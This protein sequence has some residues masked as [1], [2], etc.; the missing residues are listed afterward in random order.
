MVF[1]A[2]FVAMLAQLDQ[3]K[4][5]RKTGHSFAYLLTV[6]AVFLASLLFSFLY[7]IVQTF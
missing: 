7:L 2:Y 3:G 4:T 5:K 6:N 1:L